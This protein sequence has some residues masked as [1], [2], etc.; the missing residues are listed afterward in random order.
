MSDMSDVGDIGAEEVDDGARGPRYVVVT[1]VRD[2]SEHLPVTIAAMEA[3]VLRPAEWVVVDDG[4]TD[5]TGEIAEAAAARLPWMHVV[6]RSDRGHRAAGSGVME[7]VSDG[8][9]ALRTDDWEFV[10]KLDGDLSFGPDYFARCFTRFALDPRLGIGGGVIHSVRADGSTEEER[11]PR[12][13]VRGATKIYRRACWEAIGGLVPDT[14]WDTIDEVTA[15]YRGWRTATFPELVLVQQRFTGDAAGQW[16][17]WVKNGRA[18]R[19]AGYHPLFLAARA[20]SRLTK[21]HPFRSSAGL[22]WGYAQS[23]VRR[24]PLPIDDDVKRY[25]RR[26]QM[27]R[28]LGRPSVWR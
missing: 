19:L 1:P 11:H 21:R 14:G 22:L 27:R 12:F 10:V 17:N 3:Q 13:H 5:G 16:R 8:L 23:A 26:E 15:N 6:H 18:N 25:V 9:R 28:L 7:A 20:G 4:S 2:E 24:E